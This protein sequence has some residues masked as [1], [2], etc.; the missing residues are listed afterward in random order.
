MDKKLITGGVLAGLIAASALTGTV[1]AQ[2]VADATGLTE[3][4]A[5]EIALIE[6]P[7]ELLDVE[8]ERDDG[9]TVFEVEI[10]TEE[11]EEFYVAID[12]ETGEVLEIEAE[13]DDPD[14]DDDD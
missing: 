12:A 2:A 13:D 11:D 9:T 5:I 4:Q 8:L 14:C 1:S 3:E 6:V 7:G 10:L